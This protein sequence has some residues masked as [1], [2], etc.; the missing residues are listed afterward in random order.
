MVELM[1]LKKH[2]NQGRIILAVCD[3]EIIGK[4]FEE[5]E[6]Q[7]DLSAD[8]FK[9]EKFSEEDVRK[10]IK[11]ATF[12]N[13]NGEKSVSL[14]IELGFIDSKN[15]IRISGIPHAECILINE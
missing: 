2:I 10:M 4:K 11:E 8:F 13:L 14:G 5:G 3:D 15:V 1:I 6:K 9:G 7:L 12:L